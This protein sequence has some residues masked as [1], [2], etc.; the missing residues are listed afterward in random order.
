VSLLDRAAMER[1]LLSPLGYK[2]EYHYLDF[3][4]SVCINISLF[5]TLALKVVLSEWSLIWVD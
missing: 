2:S 1:F 5:A 4:T 3:S